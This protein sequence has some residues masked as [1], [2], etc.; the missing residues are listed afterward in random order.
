MKR[1]RRMAAREMNVQCGLFSAVRLMLLFL[2]SVFSFSSPSRFPP[3]TS[4]GH[5]F[6]TIVILFSSRRVRQICSAAFS[7]LSSLSKLLLHML[8]RELSQMVSSPVVISLSFHSLLTS[9][10]SLFLLT[11]VVVLRANRCSLTL[12]SSIFSRLFSDYSPYSSSSL[13]FSLSSSP[14]HT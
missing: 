1:R 13:S 9:S 4:L 5:A 2:S 3:L 14:S 7:S 6:I 8:A 10:I 11:F 12:L